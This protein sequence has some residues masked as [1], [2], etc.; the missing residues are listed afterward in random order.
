MTTEHRQGA[1]MDAL[2]HRLGYGPPMS[3]ADRDATA[4]LVRLLGPWDVERGP[5]A[6]LPPASSGGER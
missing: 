4:L 1:L 5:L 2:T 3:E 6:A